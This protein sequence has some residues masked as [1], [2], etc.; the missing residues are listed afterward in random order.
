MIYL[1][2]L[3]LRLIAVLEG[4]AK[5]ISFVVVFAAMGYSTYKRSDWKDLKVP[6]ELVGGGI[7][8]TAIIIH[9]IFFG[10]FLVRDIA[11]LFTFWI[12]FAFT[13]MQFRNKTLKHSLRYILIAFLIFNVSNY[14]Y[15]KLYF[16]DQKIG[17]NSLLGLFGIFDYRIYF[18]LSSGA[19]IYTSQLGFNAI[20][21]LYF[22]KQTNKKLVYFLV[23]T[24]YIFMLI[25][26]D[27][28]QIL[29]LTILFSVIYWF[30]LRRIL[31]FLKKTWWVLGLLLM[32]LLVVFYNSSFLDS[33]KRPGELDGVAIN[34]IEIWGI[35]FGIIFS[36]FRAF[37]GNGLHG[38]SE[39]LP[40]NTT[41]LF[42]KQNLETS[43][44]FFIQNLVDFGLIGLSVL[45][46]L[47]Y[48]VLLAVLKT[49]E[50]ILIVLT[51][52][53]LL[54]GFTESIPTFYSFEPTLFVIAL[55]S[56]IFTYNERKSIRYT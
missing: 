45:I 34:R 43:H 23:Y 10:K 26:A 4:A 51:V 15:F 11:V 7:L 50:S 52:F 53:I 36:S 39:N 3:L 16:Y 30:S 5:N 49:R 33:V 32:L 27:S 31:F 35:A 9:T 18:P 46:I 42:E 1:F 54:I 38:L 28:R 24:F 55:L 48:N 56:I 47:V 44:N 13:F 17:V 6:R 40:K 8:V 12:W 2:V 29:L 37:Y 25:L 22:I 21:S 14:I 41:A 19:N 20:L